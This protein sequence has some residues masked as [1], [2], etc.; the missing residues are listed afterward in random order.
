V[1]V[2]LNGAVSTRRI[3]ASV[4]ILIG[5]TLVAT[6]LLGG[7]QPASA[8]QGF[9]NFFGYQSPTRPKRRKAR[10]RQRSAPENRTAEKK[11]ETPETSGAVYAVI[12]IGDQHIS[13]YDSTGRIAQSSVSTGMRGHRT[14]TGVFS[15]IGKERYHY[16]NLYGSAP[17]PWM[18]RITWSGVA[19][20]AGHVPGYPASH[21][22]I[23]LP[24]SF[25]PRMWRMT[26]MGARVIVAPRDTT[27]AAISH[28]FLPTPRMQ[29][30][31]A[32]TAAGSQEAANTPAAHVELASM[33]A[34]AHVA[35]T[36]PDGS[37]EAEA[38]D[39]EASAKLLNPIAYAAVLKK[40]AKA[41]KATAEQTEKDALKAAQD[42]GAEARQ[43]VKD[44]REAET[45]LAAAEAQVAELESQ[46][47][48]A[49]ADESAED[50]KRAEELANTR[51]AAQSELIRA[52]A[53]L[54]EAR[55]REGAKTPAAFAAVQAW[56]DAV[57]ATKAAM[58]AL[59]EAD[60]RSEP[61]SVFI[62]KKEGR[63]FIRQDWKEVYEAP[64]TIR[65]P[66]RP[67][68]THV[69]IAVAAEPDGSAMRWSA[70]SMP[71]KPATEK[72]RKSSKKSSKNGPI[73]PPVQKNADASSLP[74]T[75]AGALDRIELPPGARE[76]ISELLWTGAS[77]IVSDHGRSHEMG[78][79]TDFIILTR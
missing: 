14:P 9:G 11:Q 68:G 55:R 40:R 63:I 38:D 41:D 32:T 65:D 78:E 2:F 29:P 23:R 8:Q 30:A 5:A 56:K 76:R 28:D 43:A 4:A 74:E 17:M 62:S 50:D 61:V 22:C 70:V 18:Q 27:P 35:M 58:A 12:S 1:H 24:Y 73:E 59:K 42:A 25:A 46:T 3:A 34:P 31:A 69:Y 26:D 7:A 21:G 52:R 49:D 45:E 51:T 6:G 48:A 16:S 37:D 67:L 64:V 60:R 47:S 79:Y 10:R 53:A 20:H 77:L 57:A 13:I 44:V 36:A 39:A 66:D 75:A 33:S 72:G 19:M 71:P 15:V 54:E